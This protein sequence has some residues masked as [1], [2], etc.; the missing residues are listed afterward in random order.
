MKKPE[1]VL[2][3]VLAVALLA[4][5]FG[6]AGSASAQSGGPTDASATV[7]LLEGIDSARSQPG[8]QY[9]AVLDKPITVSGIPIPKGTPA[10]VALSRS[11]AGNIA[12]WTVQLTGFVVGGAP[13]AVRGT[14]P[15]LPKSFGNVLGAVN[16]AGHATAAGLR[17]FLQPEQVVTFALGAPMG[18]GPM[19]AQGTPQ[20]SSPMVQE[21]SGIRLEL[22]GCT[23]EGTRVDCEFFATN[24]TANDFNWGSAV[25]TA[26]TS[27]ALP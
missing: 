14:S 13:V 24:V 10:I 12:I 11:F 4:V 9:R 21:Q 19:V 18:G 1:R 6:Q 15:T 20:G 25:A 2:R 17:V 8:H 5:W 7:T 27:M 16:S 26:A 22:T 23:K 3:S